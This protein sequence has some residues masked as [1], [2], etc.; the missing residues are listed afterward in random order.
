MSFCQKKICFQEILKSFLIR[1]K[2]FVL[3]Q[4]V[5]SEGGIPSDTRLTNLFFERCDHAEKT[6]CVPTIS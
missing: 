4:K 2:Y 6:T 5:V 1:R 3:Y